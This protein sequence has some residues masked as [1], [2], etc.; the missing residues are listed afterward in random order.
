[1]LTKILAEEIIE[2]TMV[3][4]QRNLNVMDTNGMIIA[5]GEPTRINTI[6]EGAAYVA[7][8]G[9]ILWITEN[10]L[11][12]WHGA[13][14]G[15]NMPIYFQNNLVGVIGITGDQKELNE[16][17]TL[18]QLTT[19]MMVH[20]S[21]ITSHVEWQ[22][23]IKELIFEELIGNEPISSLVIER[24]SLLAFNATSPFITL[25]IQS[26]NFH[27]SS[28]RIIEQLE[29]QFEKNTV[30]IGHSHL[31]ELFILTAK[32]DKRTLDKKIMKLFKILEKDASI[33]IGVGHSVMTIND[34]HYSYETAKNALKFSN[35]QQKLVY[36]EDIELLA[37]LKRNPSTET[38]NF[39]TRI[40]N[41]L[42]E[43]L[44]HTLDVYFSYNQNSLAA[45]EKLAIHRHTI[46]YR[47]KKVE[48][49]TGYNPSLFQDAMLLKCALLLDNTIYTDLS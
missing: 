36:Y 46:A 11:S 16:I 27:G 8:T 3:R 7:K 40:L 9:E 4:L 23:K 12:K 2:Q 45:S 24:L 15:V 22:Q 44:R 29:E 37:L 31:N 26:N 17:A 34:I 6:H 25:L 28:Q 47:L 42:N 5:S 32:L 43:Q 19:E 10:N 39:S 20:Q 21:L 30:L 1:M 41:G 33:R 48:E 18:V 49:I 13:R 35:L 14:L 38:R